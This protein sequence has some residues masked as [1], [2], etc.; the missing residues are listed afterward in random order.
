MLGDNTKMVFITAG[1]GGGTGTGAAPII[2]KICRD[3]G[4]LTVGIVTSPFKFEG[5]IRLAQAQKGIENLRKQ[6]D[7]LIVINNISYVIPME[8][9]VSRQV[10]PRLMKYLPLLPKVSLRLSPRSLK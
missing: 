9:W 3:L 2:A 10:L 6:L 4:I 5:E 7:S 1:M 8:T